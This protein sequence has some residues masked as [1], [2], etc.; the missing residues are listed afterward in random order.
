VV[1]GVGV[2]T[3]ADVQA[4]S[5]NPAATHGTAATHPTRRRV[6]AIPLDEQTDDP[7]PPP[8]YGAA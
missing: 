1:T 3:G 8:R 2:A 7:R 6:M 5:T 4:A